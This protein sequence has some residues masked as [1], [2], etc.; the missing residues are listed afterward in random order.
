MTISLNSVT[1]DND[2]FW[3][4]E[5]SYP[6]AAQNILRTV[7]GNS[8]IQTM[9]LVDGQDIV[10]IARRS[11]NIYT[12]HFTREQIE[13]FKI[14]EASATPVEFVYD[15]EVH[16]VIVKSGGVQM[17]P[18]IPYTEKNATDKYTGTLTLIKV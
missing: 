14:L 13:G 16:E 15:T 17:E 1:L 3:E 11:G 5:F 8:I 4:E 7:L 12:G 10:L 6:A 18:L 9:P 2:L